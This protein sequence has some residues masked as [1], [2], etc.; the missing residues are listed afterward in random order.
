MLQV[1]L[2]FSER[3]PLNAEQQAR[4]ACVIFNVFGEARPGIESPAL[5]TDAVPLGY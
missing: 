3:Y 5:G 1:K 4:A 2:S